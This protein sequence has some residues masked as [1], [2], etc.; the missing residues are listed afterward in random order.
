MNPMDITHNDDYSHNFRFGEYVFHFLSAAG[1][2]AFYATTTRFGLPLFFSRVPGTPML[3]DESN[4]GKL[5]LKSPTVSK[6]NGD[7]KEWTRWKTRT[8]T[9][10]IS[11]GFG[12]VIDD[13]IYDQ[14]DP[15]MVTKAASVYSWLLDACVEGMVHWKVARHQATKDG[16]AAWRDICLWFDGE[17]VQTQVATFCNRARCNTRD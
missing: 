15:V 4:K 6:F 2:A 13:T 7:P 1:A 17:H 5:T 10:F 9:T 8:A 3:Y 16:N 12:C 14:T 11:T